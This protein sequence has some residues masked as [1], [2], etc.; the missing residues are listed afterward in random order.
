MKKPAEGGLLFVSAI[1]ILFEIR[2]LE[3][4]GRVALWLRKQTYLQ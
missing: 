1:I 3:F 4:Y 2:V